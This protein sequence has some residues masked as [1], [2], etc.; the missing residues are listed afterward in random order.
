MLEMSPEGR[1]ALT[2]AFEGWA[3]LPYRDIA[4][5]VTQGYGHTNAAGDPEVLMT[6]G[7]WSQ[8]YGD[9]VLSEDL[10]RTEAEISDV[11][12]VALLRQQADAI[13]DLTFNIGI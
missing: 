5:V 13:I 9:V 12:N 4:G 1:K 3:K 2:E 7:E 6:N 11:V 8:V 10:R